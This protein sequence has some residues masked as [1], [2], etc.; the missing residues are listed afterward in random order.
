MLSVPLTS[1]QR[2]S[3]RCLLAREKEL[4]ALRT[5]NYVGADAQ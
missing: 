2:A 4:L 5:R 1:D 3:Y